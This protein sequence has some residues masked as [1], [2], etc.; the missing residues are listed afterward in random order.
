[1]FRVMNLAQALPPS[2]V[3][4]Q[5]LSPQALGPLLPPRARAGSPGRRW[6]GHHIGNTRGYLEAALAGDQA[7]ALGAV[8]A[9]WDGVL[10]WQRITRSPVAAVLMAEHVA[11]AKL[12]VDCF[13]QGLGGACAETATA[14]LVRNAEAQGQLLP[15]DAAG[16]GPLFAEHTRLAGAYITALGQGDQAEFDARFA[17]ALANGDQLAAFTDRTFFGR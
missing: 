15:R 10:D 3:P 14:A 8:G 2:M 11:L 6:W 4:P 13:A 1:M 16:Y 12:L 9:L 7:A 17:D 5:G